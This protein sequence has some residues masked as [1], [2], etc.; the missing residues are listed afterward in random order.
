[1]IA[2]HVELGLLSDE[3][4]SVFLTRRGKYVAD[5][6]IGHVRG[7]LGYVAFTPLVARPLLHRAQGWLVKDDSLI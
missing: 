4:G 6:L 5:A 7:G 1:M 2:R 3:G